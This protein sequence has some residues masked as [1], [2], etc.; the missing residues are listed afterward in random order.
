M[1]LPSSFERLI[2][3]LRDLPSIGPRQATRLAF[4]LIQ[5]GP[6]KL[7]DL[8][9]IFESASE[10]KSCEQ[11]GFIHENSTGLCEICSDKT[12]DH[13]VVLIIEKETDLLSLENTGRYHGIYFILGEMPKAGL[14]DPEQRERLDNF[15]KKVQETRPDGKLQEV[16]LGFNPTAVGDYHAGIIA[17]ELANHTLKVS[18]LGRGL[19]TGGEIEFADDE[20][21]GSALSHRN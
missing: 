13:G 19:P 3:S 12:R 16:I 10:I 4:Y 20:T 9:K 14:I 18:R 2:E 11:C 17:K 5:K 21:L 8:S 1:K 6:G 15:K 7:S